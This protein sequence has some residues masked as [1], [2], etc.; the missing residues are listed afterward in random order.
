MV[1]G[2]K[3][4]FFFLHIIPLS[5]VFVLSPLLAKPKVGPPSIK[6]KRLACQGFLS[7]FGWQQNISLPYRIL[8]F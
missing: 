3:M 4:V 8:E 2:G 1:Q 5:D 7:S 6:K